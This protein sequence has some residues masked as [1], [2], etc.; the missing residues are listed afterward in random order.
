[1][2]KVEIKHIKPAFTD[3]R[4]DIFDLLDDEKI[5]HVGL[6]TSTKGAVR[7]C[8]Y[9]NKAKQFN[10]VLKGSFEFLSKEVDNPNAEV[11]KT[12]LREGDFVSI[13]TRVIHKFVALEDESAII[14]L[15]TESRSGD[16]YESD[17]VRVDI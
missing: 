10:Y 14:D 17:T 4:G 16:G 15:N 8:H 11:I 12:I 2:E 13:P 5:L 3:H 7:A 1:M 9:H 6:I